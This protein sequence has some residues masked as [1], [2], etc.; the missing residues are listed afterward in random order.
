MPRGIP[1]VS[2]WKAMSILSGTPDMSRMLSGT[3]DMSRSPKES[4]PTMKK[5]LRRLVNGVIG[6]KLSTDLTD[7]DSLVMATEQVKN[8][9]YNG[10]YVSGAGSI[11]KKGASKGSPVLSQGGSP[12][13]ARRVQFR[14][15]VTVFLMSDDG[16][17]FCSECRKLNSDTDKNRPIPR[18]LRSPIYQEMNSAPYSPPPY[19]CS[20]THTE[21]CKLKSGEDTIDTSEVEFQ[22][23]EERER[24]TILKFVV[25]LGQEYKPDDIVVKANVSGS[26]VRLVAN[27]PVA[28]PDG[29]MRMEQLSRRFMLPMDVDP[30]M[31]T[32]R[33]DI[34][35]Q[36]TVEAPILTL[37][38]R[39]TMKKASTTLRDISNNNSHEKAH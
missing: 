37:A 26:R 20:T 11:L 16:D 2:N 29:S 17:V 12:A 13:E 34:K 19:N 24:G 7:M 21:T 15:H 28:Y 22:F 3:P 30:Y 27:K 8:S 18:C 4:P 38:R 39:E 23:L 31:V 35:G 36:L 5:K 1:K 14:Q 25:L 6:G 33:L 9:Q 10:H 32:A